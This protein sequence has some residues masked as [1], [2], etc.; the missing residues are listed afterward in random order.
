[1]AL[2]IESQ[3]VL[4]SLSEEGVT[5]NGELFEWSNVENLI[6]KGKLAM[7]LD[8]PKAQK[9]GG[10]LD[11]LVQN[12]QGYSGQ[13]PDFESL[14]IALKDGRK[15]EGYAL[16]E[17]QD[18]IEKLKKLGKENLVKTSH[19]IPKGFLLAFLLV[20]FLLLL[21]AWPVGLLMIII[22]AIAVAAKLLKK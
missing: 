12:N 17:T 21:I 2:Q 22:G 15:I 1:M 6:V 9:I 14:T 8:H 16:I 18:L 7:R 4:F 20:G 10:I 5:V 19:E 11:T 3:K 13:R